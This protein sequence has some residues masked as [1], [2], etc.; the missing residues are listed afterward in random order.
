[1]KISYGHTLAVESISLKVE[2]ETV[3]LFGS[4]GC[5]K[6][7]VFKAIL[8]VHDP[9]MKIE[10]EVLLDG[11]P[12]KKGNG[13]VG[14][15]FQGPVIPSWMRLHDLCR[16]GCKV[17]ELEKEEQDKKITAMLKRFHIDHLSN[18][19]P[20][21]MS[22]GEKQ[23]AA[24]AVTLLNDPKILLLDEPTTFIDGINR[25]KIWDFVE[26]FIRPMKIPVLVVSHDPIEAITLGDKIL[27]LGNP[28]K[29]IKVADVP[30]PHPR[31]EEITRKSEF[32]EIKKE[33]SL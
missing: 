24:L 4:S 23:R 6:T 1:M 15:V 5:G 16:M 30:F 19:F 25:I 20:S 33:I 17:R 8:G 7:S 13:D 27:V 2:S 18:N 22:G 3:V 21:Q 12:N 26:N 10:G 31:S 11:E 32:W 28:A 14:M 9:E 29:I